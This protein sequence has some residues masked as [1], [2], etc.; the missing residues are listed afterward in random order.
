MYLQQLLVRMT[1]KG[2]RQIVGLLAGPSRRQILRTKVKRLANSDMTNFA[3]IHDIEF[4]NADLM[5]QN[6]VIKLVHLAEQPVDLA[7]AQTGHVVFEVIVA[8]FTKVGWLFE[9]V[10]F[11]SQQSRLFISQIVEQLLELLVIHFLGSWFP[12]TISSRQIHF[13][14]LGPFR[15]GLF[16]IFVLCAVGSDLD[17]VIDDCQFAALI[18]ERFSDGIELA[19]NFDDLMINI[20]DVQL[21]FFQSRLRVGVE[22]LVLRILFYLGL[23]LAGLCFDALQIFSVTADELLLDTF[24]GTLAEGFI[25]E[26]PGKRRGKQQGADEHNAAGRAAHDRIAGRN[27]GLLLYQ[28]FGSFSRVRHSGSFLRTQSKLET[29]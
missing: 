22:L 10:R 21:H 4:I 20:S 14:Q 19:L 6:G 29:N 27:F 8:L 26:R 18:L 25:V 28:R 16:A 15:L 13:H 1:N 23:S 7:W 9:E 2:P 3:T 17:V 12:R 5:G 11:L 24:P